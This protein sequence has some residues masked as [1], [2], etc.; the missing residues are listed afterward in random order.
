[1]DKMVGVLFCDF[2]RCVNRVN[3]DDEIMELA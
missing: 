1:M 2:E 3:R